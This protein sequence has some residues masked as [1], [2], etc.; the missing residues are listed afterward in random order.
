MLHPKEGGVCYTLEEGGVCYTSKGGRGATPLKIPSLPTTWCKK[1]GA[2]GARR[3]HLSSRESLR[4]Q[5]T[6]PSHSS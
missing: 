1:S 3:A 4:G 2:Q 5:D 6:L